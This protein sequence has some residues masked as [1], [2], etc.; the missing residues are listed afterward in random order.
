VYLKG[1]ITLDARHP[2]PLSTG[3]GKE[4]LRGALATGFQVDVSR[5]WIQS[6]WQL[7]RAGQFLYG[8]RKLEGVT[9]TAPPFPDGDTTTAV[10]AAA[11]KAAV[12]Y[13]VRTSEK[14][15]NASDVLKSG[16]AVEAAI[17]AA[18]DQANMAVDVSH[19][20]MLPPHTQA[21]DVDPCAPAVNI[22]A[23][24]AAPVPT[25]DP[26]LAT[27]A[28]A[29]LTTAAAAA[30]A[31][32]GPNNPCHPDT[33]VA[34]TPTNPCNGPAR[35][36]DGESKDEHQSRLRRAGV[37]TPIMLVAFASLGAGV[38]CVLGL[39]LAWRV[40]GSS[41]EVHRTFAAVATDEGSDDDGCGA[42][43]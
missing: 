33:Q 27:A 5:C 20:L 35:L 21:A 32:C 9:G 7:D 37:I 26:A 2:A 19:V 23:N 28:P 16:P 39:M 25:L 42:A 8:S 40:I 22:P 38:V 6:V 4:V 36:F 34:C 13:V 31:P 29:P 12:N 17:N 1:K 30:A 18:F 43:E 24:P 11:S 41:H 15:I 10:P 3:I 14:G